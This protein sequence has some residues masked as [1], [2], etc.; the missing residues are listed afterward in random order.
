MLISDNGTLVGPKGYPRG[1]TSRDQAKA[2][3]TVYDKLMTHMIPL[4]DNRIDPSAALCMDTQQDSSKYTDAFPALKVALDSDSNSNSNDKKW[5][6]LRYAENGHVSLPDNQKGKPSP[7]RGTLYVYGTK[8][9][10]YKPSIGD[11]LGKWD[12]KGQGGDKKGR[13]LAR[14]NF[15]DGVCHQLNDGPIA[16]YR[17]QVYPSAGEVTC[18]IDVPIPGDEDLKAGEKYTLYWIWDWPTSPGKDPALGAGKD[19][20]YTTCLDV[21][22]VDRLPPQD[23]QQQDS[24]AAPAPAPAA[25]A[26]A[27]AGSPQVSAAK[28]WSDSQARTDQWNRTDPLQPPALPESAITAANEQTSMTRQTI[29]PLA[30]SS[31]SISSD[32][33][34]T[35]TSASASTTAI[36]TSTPPAAA[37]QNTPSIASTPIAATAPAAAAAAVAAPAAAS[38]PLSSPGNPA[39]TPASDAPGVAVPAAA[40]ASTSPTSCAVQSKLINCP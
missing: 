37:S 20:V 40:V 28:G 30:D 31:S 4:K 27:P 32:N 2:Q 22:I 35:A 29:I 3:G 26:A 13:L 17:R 1:Y 5:I 18:Q 8:Q 15:D 33:N 19:E 14:A 6:A 7:S 25:A 34:G 16:A 24:S 12:G 11:V 9:T 39:S 38:S 36:A 21:D 23:Q 10:D